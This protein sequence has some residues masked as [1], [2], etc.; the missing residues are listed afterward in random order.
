MNDEYSEAVNDHVDQTVSMIF[1]ELDREI[2]ALQSIA[3]SESS[4]LML[5]LV[6]MKMDAIFESFK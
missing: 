4:R 6:K 1:S 2:A 5:R 3:E